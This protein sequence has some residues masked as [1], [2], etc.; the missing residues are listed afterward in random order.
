MCR[1]LR[2]RARVER[3]LV[4]SLHVEM[5]L[6]LLEQPKSIAL[7]ASG[8]SVV[9]EHSRYGP[10]RT[11]LRAWCRDAQDFVLNQTGIYENSEK[12]V[13]EKLKFRK[14]CN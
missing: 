14:L 2:K 5:F 9:I 12:A 7:F 8:A 11:F 4:S 1:R 13:T 3:W 10:R 6:E